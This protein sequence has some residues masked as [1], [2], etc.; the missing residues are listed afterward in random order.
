M[1]AA[2]GK[3]EKVNAGGGSDGGEWPKLKCVVVQKGGEGDM[4]VTTAPSPHN[5]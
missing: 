1:G 5:V 4:C 2:R 3:T